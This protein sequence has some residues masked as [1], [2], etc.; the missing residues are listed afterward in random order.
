MH[1]FIE[2]ASSFNAGILAVRIDN[3]LHAGIDSNHETF[4]VACQTFHVFQREWILL[5]RHDG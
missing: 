1:S 5:L 2:V 4:H 3:I